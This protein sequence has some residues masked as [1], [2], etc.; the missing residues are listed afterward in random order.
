ME[1]GAV[2]VTEQT[3]TVRASMVSVIPK[4]SETVNGRT[5]T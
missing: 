1:G 2:I 3:R 5:M 4:D